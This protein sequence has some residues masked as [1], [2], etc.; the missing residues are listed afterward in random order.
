MLNSQTFMA[1]MKVNGQTMTYS[2]VRV[3][4]NK[5]TVYLTFDHRGKRQPLSVGESHQ[6]IW[7]KLHNNSIWP[8][9]LA[10]FSLGETSD[11]AEKSGETGIIY[12]VEVVGTYKKN[13]AP[14]AGNRGHV[15]GAQKLDSGGSLIFSVPR[16]HL[17]EGL[18]VYIIFSYEWEFHEGR[19]NRQEPEHRVYFT[20]YDLT[21]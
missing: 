14:P 8:I 11:K 5:P 18:A 20:S 7:L 1:L 17:A 9:H 3:E 6:E 2:N 12:D 13:T 10:G 15:Y 21:D 16:E 19:P 4:K